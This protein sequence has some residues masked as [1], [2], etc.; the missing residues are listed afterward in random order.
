MAM[1]TAV[2]AG[3]TGLVGRYLVQTIEEDAFYDR[4]VLLTRKPAGGYR[5]KVRELPAD[6][7]ELRAEALVGASHL[8]C[9][10]GTTIRKAGTESAFRTVDY[11]YVVRFAQAGLDAGAR[12]LMLV[13]SVGADPKSSNFYLK[14]KGE[15]EEAVSRLGFEGLY[16]FRPSFLLGAREE[17]RPGEQLAGRLARGLEWLLAGGLRKYRPMPAGLLASAMAAAGE[18]GSPGRHVLEFDQIVRMAG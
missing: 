16:I 17:S 11:D 8:F 13:S 10:L 14:V 5:E 18:R 3:P 15:A 7:E 9:C 4:V 6:Y 2:V 12:R 1:N